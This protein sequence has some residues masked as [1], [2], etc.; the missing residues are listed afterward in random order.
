MIRDLGELVE[1]EIDADGKRM[2]IRSEAQGVAGK[3]ARAT[4]VALPPTLRMVGSAAAEKARPAKPHPAE[5]H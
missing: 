5:T 1:T 2:V 4:G 3:V